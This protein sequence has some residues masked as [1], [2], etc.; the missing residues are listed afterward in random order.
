M[1]NPN[2]ANHHTYL[3]SDDVA[4]AIVGSSGAAA[5]RALVCARRR[6]PV[7]AEWFRYTSTFRRRHLSEKQEWV[8]GHSLRNPVP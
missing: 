7:P 2:S 4:Q 6:L 5:C 8:V 3:E 1:E